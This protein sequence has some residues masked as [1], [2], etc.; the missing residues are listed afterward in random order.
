[1]LLD[2]LVHEGLRIARL[3]PLVVPE[4]PVAD[5]IDDD[6]VVEP[7]PKGHRQADRRD[8]RLRV[9]RV[10]VN[11]RRVEALR[12]VGGVARRASLL[13]W[14]R[15]A[16]LVVGDHVQRAA[17]RVAGEPREVERLGDDA[18][19]GEG[20]V[21]MDEDCERQVRIVAALG[22]VVVRL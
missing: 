12:Q 2:Q 15:E 3:V 17:G 16:D 7:F 18:L 22:R 5:E 4:P 6:V 9:V 19:A 20:C 10:H 21:S 13:G 14:S 1:M 11:D 8:R